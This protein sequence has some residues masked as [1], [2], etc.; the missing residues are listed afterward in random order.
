MRPL[1]K[2]VAVSDKIYRMFLRLYPAPHRREFGDPMA[3][4][5]RDQCRDAWN[6]GRHSGLLKLWLRT[7]PDLGKT[8]IAEQISKIERNIMKYVNGKNTPTL[9]LIIG[10]LLALLSLSHFV[11]P[12]QGMFMV[13]AMGSALAIF[14]KACVEFIR[15]A[16][17]YPW[18]LLRTFI[19]MFL[20]ALIL[21]AWAKLK[22]HVAGAPP[23]GN[24]PFG[25]ALMACLFA[26]PMVT[27][28]KILQFFVQ[29]RKS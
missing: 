26:N 25:M 29:R 18:V 3:Q 11:M 4:L 22:L 6:S 12:F 2:P 23:L 13:L 8:S 21:P 1:P 19:L 7:L 15:P 9:L 5:F 24:D 16:N 10:L 17:E 28:I 27:L 20:Y 14:A